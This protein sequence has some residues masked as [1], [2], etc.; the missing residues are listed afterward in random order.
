[1]VVQTERAFISKSTGYPAFASFSLAW[2]T[3]PPLRLVENA[4]DHNPSA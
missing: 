3:Y 2:Q 1:M 4:V